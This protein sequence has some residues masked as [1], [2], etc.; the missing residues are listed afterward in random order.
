MNAVESVGSLIIT[1]GNV[2][3]VDIFSYGSKDSSDE[4]L[5]KKKVLKT[6]QNIPN[7]YSYHL[8]A[9]FFLLFF[10]DWSKSVF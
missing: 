6:I 4:A 8:F 3:S 2:Q 5:T 1:S 9:F 10:F 7:M